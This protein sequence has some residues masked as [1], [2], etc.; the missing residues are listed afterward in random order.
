MEKLNDY[1]K[2]RTARDL[3]RDVGVSEAH[4]SDLRHGKRTPSLSLARRIKQATDGAV[5]Y[6]AWGFAQ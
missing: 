6:D 3:A 5:D 4:M 1:L 2:G